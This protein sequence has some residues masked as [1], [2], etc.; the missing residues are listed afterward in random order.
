LGIPL[1]VCTRMEVEKGVF[2]GNIIEPACWGEGKAI[3]G[4]DVAKTF[5]LDLQKCFFY[6]DSAEDLPLLEIVGN[7]RPTNPDTKLSTLA[8]QN[9]WPVYRF[10]DESSSKITNLA[11]T[12]AAAGTL[13][14][15]LLSGLMNGLSSMSWEEGVNALMAILERP[16]LV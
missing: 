1:V 8:F 14:P 11:R 3:A 15:A 16:P 7:P 9:D 5:G 6:T 4:R 10:N 12:G 2:T 13:V